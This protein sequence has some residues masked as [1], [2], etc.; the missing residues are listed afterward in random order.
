M[1]IERSLSQSSEEASI[2][3]L[4]AEELILS[5]VR[6]ITC[7]SRDFSVLGGIRIV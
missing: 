1:F 7:E 5:V 6:T 2:T 4:P 3:G